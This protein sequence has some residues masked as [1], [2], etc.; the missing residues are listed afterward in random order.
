MKVKAIYSNPP[1]L[2]SIK[3]LELS[4]AYLIEEYRAMLR[5]KKS[6]KNNTLTLDEFFNKSK[7]PNPLTF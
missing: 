7:K 1:S 3:E 2:I 4:K 5:H 6:V